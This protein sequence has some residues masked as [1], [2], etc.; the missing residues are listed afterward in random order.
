MEMGDEMADLK[1]LESKEKLRPIEA[2]LRILESSIKGIVD[3]MEYLKERELNMR[4]TNGRF[5]CFIVYQQVLSISYS[6][7]ESTNSRVKWLNILSIAMLLGSGAWQLLY[8]K[9]FFQSKKLI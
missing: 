7:T 5:N 3:E 9:R 8:L 6:Y 2:E 1:R 4:N